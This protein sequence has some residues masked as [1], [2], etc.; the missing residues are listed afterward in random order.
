MIY[1]NGDIYVGNFY[2]GKKNGLGYIMNKGK[3]DFIGQWYD[4]RQD[5]VGESIDIDG[6]VR[7][8]EWKN[9]ERLRWL[10]EDNKLKIKK[11]ALKLEPSKSQR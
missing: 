3:I 10:D 7:E 2:K 8:G 6:T 9:G 4:D 11:Q 5:G 1:E